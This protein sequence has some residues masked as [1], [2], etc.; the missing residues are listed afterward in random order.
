MI[1]L[2]AL[3]VIY[4]IYAA[5]VGEAPGFGP[6]NAAARTITPEQSPIEFSIVICFQLG[7]GLW[8][9]KGGLSDR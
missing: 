7:I 1:I 6:G 5:T 9:I 2:G 8:M 4:T 3:L